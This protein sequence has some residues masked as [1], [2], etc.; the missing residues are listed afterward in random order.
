MYPFVDVILKLEKRSRK[1]RFYRWVLNL[2]VF[3]LLGYALLL[4]I[5]APVIFARYSSHDVMLLEYPVR[6]KMLCTAITALI[7]A[8]AIAFLLRR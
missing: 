5:S 6:M 8:I 4:Y 1:Y 3:F 7:P 2:T